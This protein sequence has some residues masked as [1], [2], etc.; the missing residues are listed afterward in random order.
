MAS[1]VLFAA[2]SFGQHVRKGPPMIGDVVG[3]LS[4]SIGR[5][6]TAMSL[7]ERGVPPALTPPSQD[8]GPTAE[9]AS[10]L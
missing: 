6:A 4:L 1:G 9:W 10:S 2:L 5:C 7:Q 3:D 8:A